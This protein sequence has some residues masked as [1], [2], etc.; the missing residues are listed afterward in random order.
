MKPAKW[1]TDSNPKGAGGQD[2]KTPVQCYA[3]MTWAQCLKRVFNIDGERCCVCGG[4]PKVIACIEDRMM[5]KKVLTH[6]E[7]KLWHELPPV[8]ALR[9]CNRVSIGLEI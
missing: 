6:M 9:R 8:A 2:E 7:E 1:G 5:I 3:A 4:T